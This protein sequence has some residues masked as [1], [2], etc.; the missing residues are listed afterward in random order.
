MC[1]LRIFSGAV[2]ATSSM[3]TPP[4]A[5]SMMSGAFFSRSMTIER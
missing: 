5:D 3:S 2:R 1:C 4:S